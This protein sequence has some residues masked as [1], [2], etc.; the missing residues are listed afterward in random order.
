VATTELGEAA[1]VVEW[2]FL[3]AQGSVGKTRSRDEDNDADVYFKGTCFRRQRA[4]PL[5]DFV[6]VIDGK[7]VVVMRKYHAM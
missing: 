4:L 7:F 1:M 3:T 2:M 6:V 5:D